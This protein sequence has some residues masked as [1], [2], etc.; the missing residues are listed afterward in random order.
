MADGGQIE[1]MVMA[2]LGAL[3]DL[4]RGPAEA[5]RQVPVEQ[6]KELVGQGILVRQAARQ[7]KVP[8]TT[9]RNAL[10]GIADHQ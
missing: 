4:I 3:E 5:L 2:P 6:A 10:K 1:E 7:V 8:E 9:L